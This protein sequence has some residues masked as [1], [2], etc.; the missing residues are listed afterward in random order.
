MPTTFQN[1][2]EIILRYRSIQSVVHLLKEYL[3]KSNYSP[4]TV[5]YIKDEVMDKTNRIERQY[6]TDEFYILFE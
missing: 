1:L 3:L 2:W 6:Y 4:V 5:M